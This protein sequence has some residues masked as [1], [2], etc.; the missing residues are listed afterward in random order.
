MFVDYFNGKYNTF[1]PYKIGKDIDDVICINLDSRKDRLE[2]MFQ[3]VKKYGLH[4]KFYHPTKNEANPKIGCR[5]SHQTIIQYAKNKGLKNILILE[6]DIDFLSPPNQLSILPEEYDLLFF[7]GIPIRKLIGN[8]GLWQ[9]W[10]IWCAHAYIVNCHMYNKILEYNGETIDWFYNN[11]SEQE[12][13]KVYMQFP[14]SIYQIDSISDLDN[15]NKWTKEKWEAL[16]RLEN[17]SI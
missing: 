8:I 12:N 5:D 13:S 11:H 9:R 3:L 2:H 6:D 15:K 7:G 4:I 16:N 17:I 1:G 14:M 10:S